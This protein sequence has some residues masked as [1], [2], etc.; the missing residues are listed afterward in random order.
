MCAI[1]F[2][3]KS[4]EHHESNN[5][6][7]LGL[8]I[9]LGLHDGSAVIGLRQNG[10]ETQTSTI[11]PNKNVKQN[12]QANHFTVTCWHVEHDP[13]DEHVFDTSSLLFFSFSNSLIYHF[14]IL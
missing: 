1:I 3:S 6:A 7:A 13:N 10:N 8:P 2:V 11:F 4:N 5:T 14:H 9:S 12:Q